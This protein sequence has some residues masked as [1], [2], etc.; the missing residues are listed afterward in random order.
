VLDLFQQASSAVSTLDQTLNALA[1]SYGDVAAS[2]SAFALEHI[3]D[4]N[5]GSLIVGIVSLLLGFLLWGL[6]C[7][8]V[9]RP[10]IAM[11]GVM[12]KLAGGS[13]DVEVPYI[14]RFDEIGSMANA[15]NVFKENALQVEALR[16]EQEAAAARTA[17]ERRHAL[18]EMATTFEESVM[19]I[20]R[21]V[22]SS[23]TEMH[24][25]A[26]GLSAAAHQS[27]AQA[28]SVAAASTQAT[29]NVETVASAAE[30]LSASIGEITHQ[31]DQASRVSSAAA[32]QAAE[33]NV[34]VQALAGTVEKIGGV[35]KLIS[36]IAEQTNLLALN[37]TIEAA[38]AG[39]AGKGFAVVAGEVKNLANQ[40]SRATEEIGAQIAS[41]Q[42]DTTKTVE[43]IHGIQAVIEQVQQI[44]TTIAQAVNQQGEATREI[45][46][47]VQQAAAGTHDVTRN[48][49][50]VTQAAVSTGDAAHQ[51]LTASA[52][53]SKNA[54]LLHE[55]VDAF[56]AQIRTEKKAVL[57]PWSDNLVLG[58]ASIDAQH[59]RLVEMIND[60]Y[61]GFVTGKAREA[62]GR[63]L[64]GLVD[65]TATHF[66]HEEVIFDQT[67]YPDRIGH[68]RQHED[69]VRQVMEIQA[70]FKASR[71]SVLSQDVM[72]FLKNWLTNHILGSDKK[73]VPHMR[74]NGV[75]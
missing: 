58:I 7:R 43:A 4:L 57:M 38:R 13:L 56:L 48:I 60:L 37:A 70:K 65:Y 18:D 14:S 63:V 23:S 34:M 41:V 64:D 2:R 61:D 20:V 66:K 11:T 44:S 5:D 32:G 55:E 15:V 75:R 36:D 26:Q 9:T 74:A 8:T 53:L 59:K 31:V 29:A 71:D 49:E 19:N 50:G 52:D 51:V 16:R 28:Q 3:D 21:V 17:E 10:V 22:S 42:T 72:M 73:Y 39:E 68:K 45:A 67:V 27:S 30:E 25:S 6:S 35:A 54:E 40:T 24:A 12:K 47:N 1:Q 69:L 33:T 62:V 46:R